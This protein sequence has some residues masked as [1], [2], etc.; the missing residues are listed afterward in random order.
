MQR[1]KH[2]RAALQAL[3][4]VDI[5]KGSVEAAVAYAVQI[6]DL[7]DNAAA[8][9]QDLVSGAIGRQERSMPPSPIWL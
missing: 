9:C 6:N 4:Q 3:F 5:G 7:G 8:F 2:G 1:R